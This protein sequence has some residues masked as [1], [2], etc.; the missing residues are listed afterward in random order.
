[1]NK[2]NTYYDIVF[3]TNLPSF[4][5]LKLYNE[6]SKKKKIFVIFFDKMEAS[7]NSDFCKGERLF[8]YVILSDI[9]SPLRYF[10]YFKFI[11]SGNYKK[12]I[13]SGWDNI[14]TFI[15]AYLSPKRKNGI[16]IESAPFISKTGGIKALIKRILLA[17][18]SFA[19]LPGKSNFKLMELLKFKGR[20]IKTYGVGLFNLLEQAP[21]EERKEVKNFLF[22]GRYIWI[23]NL[24]LLLSAFAERPTLCLNMVGFG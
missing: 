24:P 5:K 3:V 9:K 20:Y 18:I 6:I 10:K 22:V 4:Y 14:L 13:Y 11:L 16:C 17:K 19:V 23:K 7:R 12:I 1:M 15:S 2:T 21:Y 8:D